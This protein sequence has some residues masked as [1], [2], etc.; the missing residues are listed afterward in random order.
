MSNHG[1]MT[2]PYD[3]IKQRLKEEAERRRAADRDGRVEHGPG[4][5]ADGTTMIIEIFLERFR[6]GGSDQPVETNFHHKT[7]GYAINIIARMIPELKEAQDLGA[8]VKK[9]W[10]LHRDQRQ[11]PLS[12]SEMEAA[13]Q[14]KEPPFPDPPGN[15]S[16]P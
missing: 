15:L 4:G 14:I 2:Y 6:P 1:T 11:K 5:V 12:A 3:I 13:K 10:E 8:V 9:L 16:A 7:G